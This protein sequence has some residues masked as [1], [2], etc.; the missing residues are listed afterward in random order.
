[1]IEMLN[2]LLNVNFK[3]EL[4]SLFGNNSKVVVK[5][6]NYSTNKKSYVV[7]C[8]LLV[9]EPTND[10]YTTYPNGLEFLIDWCWKIIGMTENLI[11]ITSIE[12]L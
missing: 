7:H 2:Y 3:E 1:M 4:Y 10:L 8:N 5:T 11:K 12:L 9:D 6:F